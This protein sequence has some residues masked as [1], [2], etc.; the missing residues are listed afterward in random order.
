[1]EET[2]ESLGRTAEG[3]TMEKTLREASEKV[4][5]WFYAQAKRDD[6]SAKDCRF[7]T[8]KDAYIADSKNFRAMANDLKRALETDKAEL[9]QRIKAIEFTKE[10]IND[11]YRRTKFPMPHAVEREIIKMIILAV[12]KELSK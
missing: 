1:M 11:C 6:E 5:N 9:S 7:L 4:M 8:L 12:L 2:K 3:V 10:Q